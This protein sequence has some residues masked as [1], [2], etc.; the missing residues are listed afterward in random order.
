[1]S[2][3]KCP[4]IDCPK[5]PSMTIPYILIG[6][7]LIVLF[8]FI[9]KSNMPSETCMKI[10]DSY[11]KPTATNKTQVASSTVSVG[12]ATSTHGGAINARTIDSGGNNQLFVPGW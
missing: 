2:N 12:S 3:N 10:I 1:M 6:V 7:C 8:Y 5:C 11:N 4:S 9:S